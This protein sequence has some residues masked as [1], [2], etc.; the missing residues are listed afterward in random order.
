MTALVTGTVFKRA[1]FVKRGAVRDPSNPSE[2][3]RR[4]LWKSE[5]EEDSQKGA[6]AMTVEEQ[7]A[8]AEKERDDERARREETE[9][10]LE[11]ASRDS[12]DDDSDDSDDDS[13][14]DEKKTRKGRKANGQFEKSELPV[15]ARQALEKAER[16]AEELRKGQE[17]LKSQLRQ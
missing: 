3:F 8:K 1:T 2:P 12:D 10:K 16:D 4:L 6:P 15:A 17:L 7:L 11:K 9:R 14:D 13:D 5:S